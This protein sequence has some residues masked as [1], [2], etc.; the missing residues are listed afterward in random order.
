MSESSCR[1]SQLGEE[2]NETREPATADL[3]SMFLS[4]LTSQATILVGDNV[5]MDNVTGLD[6][7]LLTHHIQTRQ[8]RLST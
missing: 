5:A 7:H 2:L 6:C 8:T 4:L 1:R 3:R